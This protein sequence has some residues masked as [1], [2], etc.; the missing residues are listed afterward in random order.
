MTDTNTILT[1]PARAGQM[2]TRERFRRVTSDRF[3]IVIESRDPLFY[4]G[5]TGSFLE[6]LGAAAVEE[7]EA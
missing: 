1:G 7:L 5:K 2:T 3:F 6:S 4:R